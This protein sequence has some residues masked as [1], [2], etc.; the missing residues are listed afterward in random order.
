MKSSLE[1]GLLAEGMSHVNLDQTVQK[2][3]RALKN[4]LK[5]E[6]GRKILQRYEHEEAE[7]AL[8]F[9]DNRNFRTKIVDRT[10]VDENGIRWIIDYKTGERTGG[11]IEGFFKQ[12]IKRYRTQLESYEQLIRLQGETRPIKKA[13]YYPLHQTLG[14][15]YREAGLDQA[16]P[17][18]PSQRSASSAAAQPAPAAVTACRYL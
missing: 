13:L 7:Y 3:L 8:T 18:S 14:G 9:K 16:M 6:Q 2:G 12:E 4:I 10:Y 1:A 5:D 15:N 17:C 11:N